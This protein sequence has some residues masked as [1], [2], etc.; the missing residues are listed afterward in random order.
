MSSGVTG[1]NWL[2]LS[3]TSNCYNRMYV[4]G[5]VDISGGNLILRNNNLYMTSGD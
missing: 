3:S 2:D 1:T 5:F 4:Q